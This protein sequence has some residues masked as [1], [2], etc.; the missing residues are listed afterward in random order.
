MENMEPTKEKTP[1]Q[2][3]AAKRFK[4]FYDTKLRG[5]DVKRTCECGSVV[6]YMSLSRHK[7]SPKHLRLMEERKEKNI[8]SNPTL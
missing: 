2:I 8:K 6:G 7:K 1:K 3:D 5:Q 4:K